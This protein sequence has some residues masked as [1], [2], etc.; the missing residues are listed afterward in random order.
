VYNLNYTPTAFGGYKVEGKI[1]LKVREQRV[2]STALGRPGHR[3]EEV[4]W[5]HLARDKRQPWI[6][7]RLCSVASIT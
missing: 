1:H 5:M 4:N 2:E 7:R 6:L 3:R